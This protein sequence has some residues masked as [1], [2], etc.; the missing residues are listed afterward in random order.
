MP[1]VSIVIPVFNV[2][3]YLKEC[4]DSLVN[5]T[6]KDIEI[7]CIDDGSTDDSF[8]ILVEYAEKDKRIV[9]FQQ[10][11][12][13]AACARNCGLSIATGEY[14]SFLDSDDI[15]SLNLF[16]K[17]VHKAELYGSDIVIFK[18][19][20]FDTNSNKKAIMNDNISK[21]YKTYSN[22]FSYVD[23][24]DEIFNSFLVPA[25]N[26]V[27]RR[28]FVIENDLTFQNVKR[29]NDLYFSNASLVLAS[30][31]TLLD[32]VLL[33]YRVGMQSNLQSGND[34]TPLEFYK[35]LLAVK[36]FLDRHRI[37]SV[38]KNSFIKLALDNIFYNLNS[39][40]TEQAR[41]LIIFKVRNESLELLGIK[42][43]EEL[44]TISYS[45]Y[46]QYKFANSSDNIIFLKALYVIHKL[47][48]YYE[49]TGFKNTVKKLLLKM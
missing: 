25:W 37:Y 40:K 49:F 9:I 48:Q 44:R 30:K 14:I 45:G 1:K 17:V 41:N 47:W 33:F 34:K 16:E 8:N 43:F 13:G 18:A 46:L 10:G 22:C 4:L 5:Q 42:D 21:F 27:F 29:C 31:I 23:I 32:E 12:K 7:I 38:V 36:E 28:S 24:P 35:A 11:N 6:L 19:V 3:K 39:V 26:K 20:S 15:F 2:E